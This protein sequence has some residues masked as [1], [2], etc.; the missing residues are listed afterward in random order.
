MVFSPSLPPAIC[1][2]TSV[3][4]SAACAQVSPSRAAFC[5]ARTARAKTD[6]IIMPAL[7]ASRPSFII[8]RRV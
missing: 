5:A 4:P 8:A 7:T 6:G 2:T 1:T 3:R